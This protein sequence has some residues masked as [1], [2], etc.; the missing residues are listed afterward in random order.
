VATN[1]PSV[2]FS[3]FLHVTIIGHLIFAIPVISGIL[4]L[5]LTDVKA[6]FYI[7]IP[8]V[9]ISIPI[10]AAFAW[11]MAKGSNWVNTHAAIL[12]VCSLPGRVYGI[13]FGGLLGF[14]LFNTTGGTI[15]AILFYLLGL[16]LAIPLGKFM[17]RKVLPMTVITKDHTHKST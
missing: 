12:A 3:S 15:F 13:L 17:S 2:P 14:H 6:L 7:F 5:N 8:I 11:L 16:A 1:S 4:L 10:N 9:F